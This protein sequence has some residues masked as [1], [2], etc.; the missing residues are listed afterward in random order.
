M[1]RVLGHLELLGDLGDRATFAEHPLGLAQLADDLLR[2]VPASLH[3]SRSFLA[4]DRGRIGLSQAP[5]RTHG[6]GPASLP[7]YTRDF[8]WDAGPEW[9]EERTYC[10]HDGARRA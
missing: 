5:D 2:R 3:V 4:H 9:L 8:V 7:F 1:E 10:G 6:V